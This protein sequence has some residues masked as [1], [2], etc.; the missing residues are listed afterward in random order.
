MTHETCKELR[1]LLEVNIFL[2]DRTAFL[3]RI[4]ALTDVDDCIR[5]GLIRA[6]EAEDWRQFERYVLAVTRHPSRMAT[7]VL[8]DVLALRSEEVNNEDIVEALDIISDPASVRCLADTL[9][10]WPEW[11]EFYHLAI[12]CVNAL[13]SIGSADAISALRDVASVGPE[14]I[15]EAAARQLERYS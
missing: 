10:W 7:R 3:E 12:K 15:R 9:L 1:R 2:V 8:C 13:G 11:D 6:H 5:N 14:A 4:D